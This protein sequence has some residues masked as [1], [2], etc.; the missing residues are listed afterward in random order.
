[1]TYKEV[2][3]N[4]FGWRV[5]DIW[6]MPPKRC[7]SVGCDAPANVVAV[8]KHSNWYLCDECAKQADRIEVRL[9]AAR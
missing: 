3:S 7:E 9:Q 8:V 4:Y 1:M 5:A 2:S 6:P